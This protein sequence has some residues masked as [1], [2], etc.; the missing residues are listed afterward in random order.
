MYTPAKSTVIPNFISAVT[1]LGLRRLMLL[2]NRKHGAWLR[3]DISF[4]NG[5]WFAW[6]YADV[7]GTASD[8]LMREASSDS[9]IKEKGNE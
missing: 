5:K 7:V 6:Y 1:P 8:E 9:P 2:T 3:Y 4:V